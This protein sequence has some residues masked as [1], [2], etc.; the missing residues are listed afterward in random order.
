M[1]Q[2]DQV[3]AVAPQ[4]LMGCQ[5]ALQL[6]DGAIGVKVPL[7]RVDAQAVPGAFDI[8]NPVNCHPAHP[9]FHFKY[10]V[11]L[12]F[13]SDLAGGLQQALRK[14]KVADDRDQMPLPHSPG[15]H[16]APRW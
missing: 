2:I 6:L 13:R 8:I 1:G 16:T 3:T 15:W 12:G 9:G 10:D 5:L 11:L 14:R 4:E 7:Y